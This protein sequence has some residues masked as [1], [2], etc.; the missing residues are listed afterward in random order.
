MK[1]LF[2][3]CP[4]KGRTE[5]NIR[6]SME[7][8]HKIAE[9]IFDQEL[10][11]IPSYVEDKPPENN[12]KAIW[13][14]GKS[15]QLLANADYFIGVEYRDFFDG[16]V[17]ESDVA[18]RYDIPSTYVRADELMPDAIEVERNFWKELEELKSAS[19]KKYI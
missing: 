10:E 7:Q 2:I 18:R 6:K 3:S 9:I 12:N 1:K 15:I 13:Y 19:P 5:E 4:M 11:V 17:I 16:C 14:L 8:M